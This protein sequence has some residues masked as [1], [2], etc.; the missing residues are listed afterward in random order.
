MKTRYCILFVFFTF[1]Q[2]IGQAQFATNYSIKEGLPSNHVYKVTQDLKG[3]IWAITDNGIVKYNGTNFKIFTTKD[4]LPT[5]D[6]WEIEATPDGRV[7]FFCKASK[8]GYIEE[9]QVYNF[10]GVNSKNVFFPLRIIEYKSQILFQSMEDWFFLNENKKWQGM[11]TDNNHFLNPIRY[12]VDSIVDKE[13]ANNIIHLRVK[14]SL[15]FWVKKNNY[16]VLNTQSNKL[17]NAKRQFAY[18]RVF[19]SFARINFVNDKLQ[20]TD[21]NYTA[22]LDTTFK[23]INEITVPESF[24]SHHII[25][26]KTQNLWCASLQKGVFKIPSIYQKL[27]YFFPSEK[28]ESIDLVGDKIIVNVFDKGY[29]EYDNSNKNFLSFIEEKGVLNPLSIIDSLKKVHFIYKLE[30]NTYN[31]NSNSLIKKQPL[32]EGVKQVV[33]KD[34]FLWGLGSFDIKKMKISNLEVIDRSLAVG[35]NKLFVFKNDIVVG[36]TDGLK[37][38]VENKVQPLVKDTLFQKPVSNI[39]SLNKEWFIVCTEGYGAYATNTNKVIAFPST[40]FLNIEDAFVQENAIWLATNDGLYEYA[41]ADNNFQFLRNITEELGFAARKTNTVLVKDDVIYAGTD[42]GLIVFPKGITA[43]PQFL[44]IY[45][46]AVHYNEQ[47]LDTSRNEVTFTSNNSLR[48]GVSTINYSERAIHSSYQY[49]LEPIQNQWL[50]TTSNSLNFSDLPPNNY[51]LIVKD[52]TVEKSFNFSILPLW[53][54]TSMFKILAAAFLLG[55]LIL[56]L[57]LIRK[58]EIKKKTAKLN[59]Q[60]KLAEYELYALR[61]QMNPHFVFNSL[62]AIQYYINENDFENSERYLVKFSK[63]IRQ[64]F[65]ISKEEEIALEDE[66]QLL[67]SYLEIEKLRFRDKLN[68]EIDVDPNLDIKRHKIPSMLLQPIVENAVN[69][70]IFNKE[71][72]GVVNLKFFNIKSNKYRVE[73]IDDGVGVDKTKKKKNGKISSSIVLKDRIAILND[74]Q[75][76][77]INFTNEIAFSNANDKGNRAVFIIDRL[78]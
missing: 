37:L 10:S 58:Y 63:L 43:S 31:F 12:K 20:I 8:I 64:F 73:I 3:F 6:I 65:E 18:N 2:I 16:Y 52:E 5:N 50:Q 68:F 40:N 54:Q 4:G 75:K 29:L 23:V 1:F 49:K 72:S 74:S 22:I 53:W 38:L 17:V 19:S 42:N 25:L 60:K 13:G 66:I 59:T 62:S 35:M 69:H 34:G 9:D 55:L 36:S 70:G 46:D 15:I 11:T 71:D 14:D 39:V 67:K 44:D 7:W 61:S 57:Q 30:M 24:S 28:I 27:N 21:K 78:Q 56:V 77:A 45:F 51:Q 33:Y 76:W 41:K 26:D 47:L 32:I 48:V